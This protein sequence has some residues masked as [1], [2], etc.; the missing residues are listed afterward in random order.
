M[1]INNH[2]DLMS[3]VYNTSEISQTSSQSTVYVLLYKNSYMD[4][5]QVVSTYNNIIMC[6]PSMVIYN[7]V[8]IHL[9]PYGFYYRHQKFEFHANVDNLM[10]YRNIVIKWK[11][12]TNV[13]TIPKLNIKIDNFNTNTW[14]LTFRLDLVQ[15]L[16]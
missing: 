14:Q 1:F 13:G 3:N 9:D 10:D 2:L 7:N 5:N 11:T 12:K 6:H 16:Q 15:A 8:W 4:C